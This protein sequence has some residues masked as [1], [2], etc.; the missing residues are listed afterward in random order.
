MTAIDTIPSVTAVPLPLTTTFTPP[1]GCTSELWVLQGRWNGNFTQYINFGPD[2]TAKCMPSGWTTQS[3]FS[4][5]LACPEGYSTGRNFVAGGETRATCCPV[6]TGNNWEFVQ[7][8]T[9]DNWRPWHSIEACYYNYTTDV[10]NLVLTQTNLEITSTGTQVADMT[11]GVDGINAYGVQL[12][13]RA[14]DLTTAA[15][16]F[17]SGITS[18]TAATQTRETILG[19]SSDSSG[20]STGARVGV[21]VGCAVAGILLILVAILFFL[22]SRRGKGVE[23]GFINANEG[24]QNFRG[25]AE[26]PASSETAQEVDSRPVPERKTDYN[27][28]HSQASNPTQVQVF[29]ELPGSPVRSSTNTGAR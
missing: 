22:R 28:P 27:T 11:G 4:P 23:S 7:R 17:G 14:T 6:Y 25:P 24:G 3:Y 18:A 8:V 10:S 5:G 13:W 1:E 21:G 20:L 15:P 29:V 12:R 16:T 26:L 9:D 19:G 2:N